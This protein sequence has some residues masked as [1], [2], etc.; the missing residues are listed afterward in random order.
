CDMLGLDPLYMA[1]EGKL[2]LVLPNSEADR[3][4]KILRTHKY[5]QGAALIGDVLEP[6]NGKVWLR[7][8]LGTTRV[9]DI[10]ATE[11]L[12]RIC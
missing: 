1:N 8:I 3:A 12:P 11:M 10:L 7:T 2:I 4:L 6:S 9:L 5:G